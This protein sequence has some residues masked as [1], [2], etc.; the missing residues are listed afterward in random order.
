LSRLQS[1]IF[2]KVYSASGVTLLKTA[3]MLLRDNPLLADICIINFED[4]RWY[5]RGHYLVLTDRKGRRFVSARESGLDRG[6]PQGKFGSGSL[7][8]RGRFSRTFRYALGRDVLG[9]I[10]RKFKRMRR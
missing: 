10:S 7:Y 3:L 6:Y 8:P 5:Q 1:L 4:K 9:S 2:D